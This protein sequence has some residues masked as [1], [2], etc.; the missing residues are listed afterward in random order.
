MGVDSLGRA[1]SIA[2]ERRCCG[3]AISRPKTCSR[4]RF[5]PTCITAMISG[6]LQVGVLHID[7]VPIIERESKKRSPRSWTS[8]MSR[9]STTTWR[10]RPRRS[11][12][13]PT[14]TP[15]VR[16]LAALIEAERFIRDPK[17]AEASRKGRRRDQPLRRRG[18]VGDKRIRQDGV[19]AEGQGRPEI[20]E[21]I[22]AIIA[23]QKARRR[24]PSDAAPV[25]YERFADLTVFN[26]AMKMAKGA[27]RNRTG[28]RSSESSTC[29][30]SRL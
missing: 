5:R 23:A 26:D 30:G 20:K 29:R 19:L 13:P 15:Y 6:Q 22:E 21:N 8:T 28:P 12:S 7:D 3:D 10:C 1:R 11:V 25:A 17:N 18:Q 16:V 14:A 2:L 4:Y 24:H 27:T 9:R